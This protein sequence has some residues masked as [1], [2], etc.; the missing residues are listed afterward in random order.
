[1]VALSIRQLLASIV[2]ITAA[3]AA[4]LVAAAGLGIALVYAAS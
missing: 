4:L 2:V 3:S 1:M